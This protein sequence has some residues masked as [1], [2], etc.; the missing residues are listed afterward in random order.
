M[1]FIKR[2]EVK[3]LSTY[4]SMAPAKWY[5]HANRLPVIVSTRNKSAHELQP[6]S[7][8][9]FDWLIDVLF[10]QGEL[11]RIWDLSKGK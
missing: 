10:K 3:A 8:D 7:K 6:I 5:D 1:R 2:P 9:R 4:T 11:L